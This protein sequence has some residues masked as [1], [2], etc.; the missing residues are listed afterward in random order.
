MIF[1]KQIEFTDK[2]PILL[3]ETI[4]DVVSNEADF[5]QKMITNSQMYE[6]GIR[7]DNSNISPKYTSFTKSLK[8]KK[9]QKSN[10]VTLRDTG[11]YH[12]SIK[13]ISKKN[14][15][16]IKSNDEKAQKLRNKYGKILGLTNENKYKLVLS[17]IIPEL[18]KNIKKYVI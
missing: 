11:D 18:K 13:L 12:R 14:E 9:G 17:K 10:I 7:P 8:S 4:H 16:L 3:N 6:R 2:F 1:K 15:M 5:L